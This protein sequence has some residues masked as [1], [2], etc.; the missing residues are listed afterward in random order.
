MKRQATDRACLCSL[1]R[2]EGQPT[3]GR[4]CC[5]EQLAR[6]TGLRPVDP[7][8]QEWSGAADRR[9][10]ETHVETR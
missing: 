10:E 6:I 7:R 8:G 1:P 5:I 9:E 4:R 2:L 3:C